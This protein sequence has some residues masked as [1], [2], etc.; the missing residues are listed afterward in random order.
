MKGIQNRNDWLFNALL[1]GVGILLL[2]IVL[3]PLYFVV[4]ASFSNAYDVTNGN[5]WLVPMRPTLRGYALILEDAKIWVGYRNTILYTGI[6]TAISLA[7]TIPAGYAL[8]RRDLVGRNALSLFFAFTLFFSGGLLPTFF[9]V[10]NAGLYNTF[11]VMVL[12]FCVSVYNLI[13]TRTFFAASIP[14]ELLEAAQIDGCT[15]TRFFF[16]MVL[17]LSKAILAVIGLYYAVGN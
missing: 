13:I 15:N 1:Y 10:K 6:G 16:Q 14:Q 7:A 2:L 4:I 11:W 5:V 8:S 17:P 3:Y 12:P 9:T